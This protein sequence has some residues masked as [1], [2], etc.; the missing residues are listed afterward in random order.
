LASYYAAGFVSAGGLFDAPAADGSAGYLMQTD[1]SGQLSFAPEIV[2]NAGAGASV[3]TDG[4]TL[5]TL[6]AGQVQIDK[7]G[8]RGNQHISFDSLTYAGIWGTSGTLGFTPLSTDQMVLTDSVIKLG[9]TIK[10]C[11]F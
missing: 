5:G 9:S 1:G 4:T 7:D 11:V 10:M 8:S 6:Q 3:T 2:I